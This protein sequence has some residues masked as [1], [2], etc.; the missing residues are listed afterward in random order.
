MKIIIAGSGDTGT[1]LAKM[2]SFEKQ[3]VVLMSDQKEYLESIDS[4]FNMMTMHGDPCSPADLAEAGCRKADLFI[5]VT[6]CGT[7][8][9]TAC[10]IADELGAKATIARVESEEL[11]SAAMAEG[12]RRRGITHMVYPEA[13]VADDILA[14]T[15]HSWMVSRHKLYGGAIHLIG[16]KVTGTSPQTGMMLKDF[17]FSGRKYHVAAIR[18]SGRLIIPRGKDTLEQGDTVYFT[19]APGEEREIIEVAGQTERRMRHVMVCGRGRL[20]ESVVE[21]LHRQGVRLTLMDPD[22]EECVRMAELYPG[23]TVS[24]SEAKDLDSL[25]EEGA[26]TTDAF[27]ALGDD[28]SANI[29]AAMMAKEMGAAKSVAQIEDIQYMREGERLGIDKVVNKK[30]ITSGVIIE[31]ILKNCMTVNKVL[32]FEDFEAAEIEVGEGAKV[33]RGAVKDLGLPAELTLIGM[34][35]GGAG[36]LVEGGT[37]L[38]PGDIVLVGFLPGNLSRLERFF[39]SKGE[40]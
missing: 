9:M 1:Y 23:I 2:L 29:V 21:R 20:A 27:L 12:F 6:P 7:L 11:T 25:R 19:C 10:E 39:A 16:V 24:N 14:F 22:R 32:S 4:T 8:N 18:R 38:M 30:L 40:R 28:A 26:D 13:V 31:Y 33:T 35:R 37:R 3:D 36:M 34:V 17:A 5:G 15:G